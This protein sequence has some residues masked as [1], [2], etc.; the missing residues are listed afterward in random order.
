MHLGQW[1]LAEK[2]YTRLRRVNLGKSSRSMGWEMR[3]GTIWLMK[4]ITTFAQLEKEPGV[5]VAD[6]WAP[7]C[8]PCRALAPEL[9]KLAEQG[10]NVV[11]INVDD[12]PDLA[13]QFQVM[14]IPTVV[15]FEKGQEVRRVTGAMNAETLK[16][17]LGV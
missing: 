8:G 15:R 16:A 5:V 1:G 13:Q 17:R 11:K 3:G 6:F 7:W 10:I 12:A 14:S 9:D 4:D 2:T